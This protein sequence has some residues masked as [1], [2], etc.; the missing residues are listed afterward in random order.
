MPWKMNAIPRNVLTNRSFLLFFLSQVSSGLGDTFQLIAATSLL[1]KITGSGLAAGFG[2]ICAPMPSIV[3]SLF[4]GSLGDRLN[5]K[6]VLMTLDVLRA[7]VAILFVFAHDVLAVYILLLTLSSLDALYYP[8]RNKMLTGT[9]ES[10]ELMVGNSV[11]SGGYGLVYL[12]GPTLAGII[13]GMLDVD[14]AFYINGLSFILSAFLISNIQIRSHKRNTY[15][16]G[17]RKQR[18]LVRDMREGI[19][20][21]RNVPALRNILLTAAVISLGTISVNVAFYPFAFDTL[22]VSSK[23]WGIMLSVLYGTSLLAMLIS[24]VVSKKGLRHPLFAVTLLLLA[25]S[26]IWLC[27]GTIDSLMEVLLLQ[28]M[29]GTLLA[30]CNIFMNT[31]IQLSVNKGFLARVMGINDIVCN[32]GKL[33]GAGCTYMVLRFFSARHVFVMSGFILFTFCIFRL[34]RMKKMPGNA[35][36]REYFSM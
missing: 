35:S 2:M 22:G 15:T 18:S 25:V 10:K 16:G 7:F 31:Q 8:S 28:I 34:L 1:V 23:G 32:S 9:L 29:E 36:R 6:F 3:L 20:Y 21:C 5:E 24:M 27:Y 11:L 13:V 4:A 17:P 12:I 19:E 33:L 26:L 14:V 30:L